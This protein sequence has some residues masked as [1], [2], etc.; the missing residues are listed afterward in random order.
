MGGLLP[1]LGGYPSK[2]AFAFL[3]DTDNGVFTLH[4][5]CQVISPL[6]QAVSDQALCDRSVHLTR[7]Y[8]AEFGGNLFRLHW[9]LTRKELEY[10]GAERLQLNPI[11]SR[12]V[13]VLLSWY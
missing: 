10:L 8:T 6:N 5:A 2:V 3:G 9:F 11:I 1:A 7:R 13:I 12:H 4:E